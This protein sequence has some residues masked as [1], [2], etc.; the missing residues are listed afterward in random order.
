MV[1]VRSPT[2]PAGVSRTSAS[3]PSRPAEETDGHTGI[4]KEDLERHRRGKSR[5]PDNRKPIDI[6]EDL[7]EVSIALLR[8]FLQGLLETQDRVAQEKSR[9]RAAPYAVQAYQSAMKT[10]PDAPPPPTV[11]DDAE[12]AGFTR[13]DLAAEGLD[14]GELLELM[15][16]LGQLEAAGLHFI[17][18]EKSTSFL[19][20]VRDGIAR[21]LDETVANP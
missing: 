20:S 18:I 8:G 19:Q 6:Y 2:P 13:L 7:S 11:G 4:D 9:K 14:R 21:L 1:D 10:A 15:D 3:S 5:V 12:V 17:A 16:R